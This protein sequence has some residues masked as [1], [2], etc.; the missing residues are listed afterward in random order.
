MKGETERQKGAA[1]K[2]WPWQVGDQSYHQHR[3]A[4]MQRCAGSKVQAEAPIKAQVMPSSSRA[5]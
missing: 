2:I 1:A 4:K 3:Q 5:G